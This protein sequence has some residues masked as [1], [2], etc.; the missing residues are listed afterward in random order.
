MRRALVFAV[1]LASGALWA[2]GSSLSTGAGD[3]STDVKDG[4]HTRDGTVVEASEP[5]AGHD[6]PVL[7]AP[8]GD[9]KPGDGGMHE[10]SPGD[11][12]A[13]VDAHSDD[14]ATDATEEPEASPCLPEAPDGTSGLFVVAGGSSSTSCGSLSLP[15]GSIDVALTVAG[16]SGGTITTL[17]VGPGTFTESATVSLLNGIAIVGGWNVFGMTWSHS[18]I[19][20]EIDGPS[21][22]FSAT[23]L[24]T[25]TTLDTLDVVVKATAGTGVSLYGITSNAS[26]LALSH[27]SV[28]VPAGGP[29]LN[30]STGGPGSPGVSGGCSPPGKGL[31]GSTG[32]FGN[33]T[34]SG[35]FG[36]PPG[37]YVPA[38]DGTNGILGGTGANGT[39]GAFGSSDVGKSECKGAGGTSCTDPTATFEGG[40]GIG[41]CPGGGGYGGTPGT[42]AGCSIALY[43]WGGSVSVSGGTLKSGSGGLGGNGGN[44][45]VGAAGAA[46]VAGASVKYISSCF[47]NPG[48]KECDSTFAYADG[49]AAGGLGGKGGTGGQGGGGAGGCSY[50][51]YMGG[52]ASVSTSGTSL[53]NGT[54]GP[55]GAP[56]G[57]SGPSAN[58]N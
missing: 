48:P 58:H 45:S 32:G 37:G 12:R 33:A 4:G 25:T 43:A 16:T 42:G 57:A 56:N 35:T 26:V 52:L 54:G 51:Y 41:G 17:Y 14:A 40:T 53:D 5:D 31:T 28:T 24:S 13:D 29:G 8:P 21:P 47:Y 55:G 7:D 20:P 1:C 19:P 44:G 27:V 18:C 15:C 36:P 23:S 50:A 46:G 3:S 49:G 9:G 39:Q 2:C 11:S 34:D 6:A 22:V 38:S 10:G 30:G